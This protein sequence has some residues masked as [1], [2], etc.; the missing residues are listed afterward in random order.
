MRIRRRILNSKFLILNYC[1]LCANVLLPLVSSQALAQSTAQS[2]WD[3]VYTEAQAKLGEAVSKA[4]CQACHGERLGG[5]MGP[6]LAGDEFVGGWDGKPAGE[7][8]DRIRTTMP[9][10]NEN[11]L[12]AKDTAD[13]VA[14][15][16]QLNKFPPG[17]S[18]LSPDA[19]SLGHIR[20]QARK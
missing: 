6:G 19:T 13:L 8:F 20:I 5:D 4:T 12:T 9:Q 1:V 17:Q 18:E 14:Y 16:F 2:V 10:G 7:L 15:I 3:G 11:S